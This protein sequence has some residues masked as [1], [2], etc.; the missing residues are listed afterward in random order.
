[1]KALLFPGQGVQKI[2]MLDE[3]IS[4]NSEIHDF[5]AK[6][7]FSAFLVPPG[8]PH[9]GF[10]AARLLCKAPSRIYRTLT[11]VFVDLDFG[12]NP[13]IKKTNQK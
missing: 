8:P 3:I 10:F 2:G 1:M 5:L 7:F 13:L 11:Y 9:G 12:L 6:Y 4:S